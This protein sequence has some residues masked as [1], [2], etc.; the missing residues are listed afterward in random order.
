MGFNK[1]QSDSS[2]WIFRK[3]DVRIFVPAYVDDIL[4]A[5]PKK[6]NTQWV[7]D[8]LKKRFKLRD[9]GPTSFFLAVKVERDR[10]NRTIHL[11]QPQYITDMLERYGMGGCSTADTP[12]N[13]SVTLTKDMAPKTKEEKDMMRDIPYIHAVGSLQYLAT[14]TRPDI[15]YAVSTL[16]RFNTNPGPQHW[17]AVKHLFRYLK[18]T[19]NMRLTYSFSGEE[20]KEPFVTFSDADLGGDKDAGKSTS[21]YVVKMGNG[22]ISWRSKLQ[23]IIA[24][25]TTESEYIAAVAA[26]AELKWL[27][28][29]FAEFGY[30]IRGPS[31]LMID[32]QSAISVSKNPEHHGRVK[33]LD[34]DTFWLRHEVAA[35]NILPI[36]IPSEKNAADVMTKPLEKIKHARSLELLGLVPNGGSD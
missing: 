24:L 30:K 1:V 27:R 18:K 11:S 21:G 26:G 28:N 17:Q 34:L 10:P 15:A 33:Q 8:E 22:A 35:G 31:S 20:D 32:N 29:L 36:H 25:S 19:I 4:I 14:C 2:V 6:H 3:G 7:K 12:M 9:L 13:A 5:A 16:A 23:T